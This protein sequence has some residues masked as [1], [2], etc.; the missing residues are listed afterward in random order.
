VSSGLGGAD[1]ASI[2]GAGASLTRARKAADEARDELSHGID[3]IDARRGEREVQRKAENQARARA[4]AA[5]TLSF[6]WAL[7]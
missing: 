2:E 4:D 5:A 6:L 1:R 3:P 7:A